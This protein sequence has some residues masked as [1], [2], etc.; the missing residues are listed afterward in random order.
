[1]SGYRDIF[2]RAPDEATATLV[3][4]Q[5]GLLHGDWLVTPAEEGG[6]RETTDPA[7]PALW[8][9]RPAGYSDAE[10]GWSV[11][12]IRV[13]GWATLPAHD[14]AGAVVTP[15]VRHAGFFLR[16][17]V[18]EGRDVSVLE[19]GAAAAGIDLATAA[20]AGR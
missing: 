7:D 8:T 16:I 17:R 3:A 19:Q 13:G 20:M 11:T 5:L 18:P 1:M 9:W 15:G 10:G 14:G 12:P 6:D 2:L 4:V